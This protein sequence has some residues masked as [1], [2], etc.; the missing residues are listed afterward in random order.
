[1]QAEP[2]NCPQSESNQAYLHASNSAAFLDLRT[3]DCPE[4]GGR[5]GFRMLLWVNAIECHWQQVNDSTSCQIHQ[6]TKEGAGQQQANDSSSCLIQQLT[7]KG[8]AWRNPAQNAIHFDLIDFR[9]SAI[10]MV[11][12]LDAPQT[13]PLTAVKIPVSTMANPEDAVLL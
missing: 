2:S 4:G 11:L 3:Q 9:K 8:A 12:M 10:P 5:G 1:M 6:L 7:I 13:C